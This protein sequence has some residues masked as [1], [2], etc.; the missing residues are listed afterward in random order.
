MFTFLKIFS[1]IVSILLMLAILVQNRGAG[2]SAALGGGG[3]TITTTKRG[4]E[5]V[6]YNATIVLA[7]LFVLTSIAFIFV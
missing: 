2:L 5:K 4:A 7:I 3:D 1:L 6:L